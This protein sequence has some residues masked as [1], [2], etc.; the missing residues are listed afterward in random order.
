VLLAM[1][2]AVRRAPYAT[3]SRESRPSE[4]QHR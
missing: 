3:R 4:P 2:V 1:G